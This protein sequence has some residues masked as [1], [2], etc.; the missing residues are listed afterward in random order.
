MRSKLNTKKRSVMM[1]VLLVVGFLGLCAF[2]AVTWKTYSNQYISFKYPDTY[3]I[4]DEEVT[5]EGY[6]LCCELKSDD[7]SMVQISIMDFDEEDLDNDLKELALSIGAE[8][9]KSEIENN[10]LYRNVRC[11]SVE[12]V[13]K[14][15]NT[16]YG[17]TFSATLMSFP[18][19]GECFMAF[20]GD[21]LLA[22]VMQAEN[23]SYLRELNQIAEGMVVK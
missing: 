12:K 13:T 8:A 22:L 14:G 20:S 15:R 21:R 9:M 10:E 3:K 1:T 11:S 6:D 7:I 17:L 2:T 19:Q 23:A 5:S 4:T 16:G 18:I